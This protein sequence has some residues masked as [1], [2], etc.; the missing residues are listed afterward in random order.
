MISC[1]PHVHTDRGFHGTLSYNMDCVHSP[2]VILDNPVN[3]TPSSHFNFCKVTYVRC[4]LAVEVGHCLINAQL[5]SS[6]VNGTD[7]DDSCGQIIMA[8]SM[9]TILVA[10]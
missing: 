5:Y 9:Y 6:D 4:N 3:L 1:N 2:F 10:L 7:V 8:F